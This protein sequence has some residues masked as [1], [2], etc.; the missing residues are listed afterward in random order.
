MLFNV[1]QYAIARV[2]LYN[3]KVNLSIE[4]PL[5]YREIRIKSLPLR[6]WGCKAFRVTEKSALNAIKLN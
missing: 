5:L 2:N 6:T 3:G 1:N 4:L